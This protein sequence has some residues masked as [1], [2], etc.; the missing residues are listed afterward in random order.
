MINAEKNDSPA[1]QPLPL[2]QLVG[3]ESRAPSE[4]SEEIDSAI[5][6]EAVCECCGTEG[7]EFHP[8]TQGTS[9]RAYAVCSR[10]GHA[11]EI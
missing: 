6:E 11:E 9:Y 5:C 10:C 8:F 2:H 4:V 1:P 7:L 3:Y